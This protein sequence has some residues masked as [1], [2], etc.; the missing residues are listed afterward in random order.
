METHEQ[1]EQLHQR[2]AS[3]YLQ[4]SFA[5]AMAAW[6]ELLLLNGADER[7]QEGVRVCALVAQQR[8]A[9]ALAN[10]AG[11]DEA[12]D[13]PAFDLTPEPEALG[14]AEAL[15]GLDDGLA[16][17]P[18]LAMPGGPAASAPIDAPAPVFD[19]AAFDAATAGFDPNATQAMTPLPAAASPV[20]P[21]PATPRTPQDDLATMDLSGLADDL[22]AMPAFQDSPAP[23]AGT[24]IQDDKSLAGLGESLGQ[25]EN[26][27]PLENLAATPADGTSNPLNE[28]APSPAAGGSPFDPFAPVPAR[29]Q[30]AEEGIPGAPSDPGYV[31][32]MDDDT[33][34]AATRAAA[35]ELQRRVH[36]LLRQA[37]TAAANEERDHATKLVQRVLILD[38]ENL[39][40]I[41]LQAALEA[42]GPIPADVL[43]E[44]PSLPPA[45]APAAGESFPFETNQH[46]GAAGE[47]LLGDLDFD[48]IGAEADA[49]VLPNAYGQGPAIAPDVEA[50]GVG[51]MPSA[52]TEATDGFVDTPPIA[53]EPDDEAAAASSAEIGIDDTPSAGEDGDRHAALNRAQSRL[54]KI[55]AEEV[56]P[57]SSKRLMRVGIPIA[58]LMLVGALVWVGLS[59]MGGGDEPVEA[60]G[61]AVAGMTPEALRAKKKQKAE[62]ARKAKEAAAAKKAAEEAALVP[63][64]ATLLAWIDGGR[65][66]A[67]DGDDELA[68]TYFTRVLDADPENVEAKAQLDAA[69]RRLQELRNLENERKVAYQAFAD[70]DYRTAL[71]AF[72][73]LPER[74]GRDYSDA[75]AAGWYNI[76]VSAMQRGSCDEA[77][78]AFD[79]Y[80]GFQPEATEDRA[81]LLAQNCRAKYGSP[82]FT[83]ALS[84]LRLKQLQ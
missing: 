8:A 21:A 28:P 47:D 68:A 6:Q 58:A 9:A 81:Y 15:A 56:A 61:T 13:V 45:V 26:L 72:Y 30:I 76:G 36:E 10:P 80:V 14:Q 71:R 39:P 1:I 52:P 83:T 17:I 67:K 29:A 16:S 84:Q 38:E 5:D 59:L 49:A 18:N 64:A 20:A 74:D 22:E 78:T 63:D 65:R 51:A 7:A 31:P 37:Q 27:D 73:R 57:V 75:I 43:A 2:A 54:A 33:A 3:L 42:G 11:V 69:L 66:A 41:R 48:Q 23:Q 35:A 34:A 82:R 19:A 53:G 24:S 32:S 50:L 79:E 46:D 60:G 62:A 77:Q 40:A 25:L 44:I 55:Q 70:G 4:G 12:G